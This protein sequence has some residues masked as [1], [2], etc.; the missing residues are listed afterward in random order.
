VVVPAF[1]ETGFAT[2]PIAGRFESADFLTPM[3]PGPKILPAGGFAVVIASS[4]KSPQ[5]IADVKITTLSVRLIF[6][7][8]DMSFIE[9]PI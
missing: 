6:N 5:K 1:P 8:E 3:T 2:A 9:E 7:Q 4:A